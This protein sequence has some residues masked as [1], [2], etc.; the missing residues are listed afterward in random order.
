V[1]DFSDSPSSKRFLDIVTRPLE[2]NDE[3]RHRARNELAH[4]IEGST[5]ATD[6]MLE[7]AAA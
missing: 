3:L 6:E 5:Q 1:A 7:D 4:L 2:A